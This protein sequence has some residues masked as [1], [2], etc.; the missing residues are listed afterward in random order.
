LLGT[1]DITRGQKDFTTVVSSIKA[2]IHLIA[3]DSDLFF[4]APAGPKNLCTDQAV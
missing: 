2:D 4:Y 1:I 3:I